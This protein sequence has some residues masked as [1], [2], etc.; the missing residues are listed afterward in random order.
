R[1]PSCVATQIYVS[2]AR[3]NELLTP[4]SPDLSMGNDG[5]SGP[6]GGWVSQ[7][8][9]EASDSRG[10]VREEPLAAERRSNLFEPDAGPRVANAVLALAGSVIALATIAAWVAHGHDLFDSDHA[11]GSDMALAQYAGHHAQIYPPLFDGTYY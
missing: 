9:A 6:G 5:G 4:Q 1:G 3:M 10:R 7:E 2:Q 8:V 11:A